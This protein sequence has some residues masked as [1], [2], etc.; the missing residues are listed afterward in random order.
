MVISQSPCVGKAAPWPCLFLW[1]LSGSGLLMLNLFLA[2]L[3]ITAFF[4]LE[5]HFVASC[6][7]YGSF[8]PIGGRTSWCIL[9]AFQDS[10][11]PGTWEEH[12]RH[13]WNLLALCALWWHPTLPRSLT[14]VT[15]F[16][17]PPLFPRPTAD[18]WPQPS[19]ATFQVLSCCEPSGD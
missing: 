18:G 12:G 4:C 11:G 6:Y 14:L 16:L 1:I 7:F 17:P 9:G 19:L 2:S 15:Q 8:L 10:L 5:T 3:C 13:F